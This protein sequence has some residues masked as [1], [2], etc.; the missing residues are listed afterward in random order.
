MGQ[1][2]PIGIF[3]AD[4]SFSLAGSGSTMTFYFAT[5]RLC[6]TANS[7]DLLSGFCLSHNNCTSNKWLIFYVSQSSRLI[8]FTL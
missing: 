7:Y 4:C 1:K 2:H 8:T 5:I 3:L 6:V